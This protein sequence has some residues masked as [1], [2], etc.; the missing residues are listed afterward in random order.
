[1]KYKV[2]CISW[3]KVLGPTKAAPSTVGVTHPVR[4]VEHPYE[5]PPCLGLDPA[6]DSPETLLRGRGA[7]SVELACCST[8]DMSMHARLK[9]DVSEFMTVD[10][11]LDECEHGKA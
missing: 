2:H 10:S 8:E 7:E 11:F 4:S 6:H 5:Q 3:L 9:E 1:M